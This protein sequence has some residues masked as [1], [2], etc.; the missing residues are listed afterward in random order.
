[1]ADE[2]ADKNTPADKGGSTDENA[3]G[4]RRAARLLGQKLGVDWRDLPAEQVIEYLRKI[5]IGRQKATKKA[6][7]GDP[8]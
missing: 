2:Q 7:E 4:Y 6:D 8:R 1:M 5:E 3:P